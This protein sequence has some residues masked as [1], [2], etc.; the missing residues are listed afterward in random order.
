MSEL[1]VSMVDITDARQIKEKNKKNEMQLRSPLSLPQLTPCH[2]PSDS[3]HSLQDPIKSPS[4][5]CSSH[6]DS[7]S[8]L[9]C[10]DVRGSVEHPRS[11][12]KLSAF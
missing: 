3:P 5:V 8:V 10:T 12:R 2:C 1:E 6:I 4:A 9:K 11:F 7:L